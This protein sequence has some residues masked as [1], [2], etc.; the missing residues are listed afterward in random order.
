ME[1][2][3]PPVPGSLAEARRMVNDLPN[4]PRDVVENAKLVLNELLANEIKH[5]RYGPGD[6]LVC[7]VE[8]EPGAV[9]IEVRHSGPTF[10]MPAAP[11]PRVLELRE[12]GWG[13]ALITRIADRWGVT[14]REGARRVWAEIDLPRPGDRHLASLR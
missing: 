13:L 12:T 4:A 10:D 5:G 7:R 11:A 14:D 9:R 1:A 3:L 8:R 6:P 2:I